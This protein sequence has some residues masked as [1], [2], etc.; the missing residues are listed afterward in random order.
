[1]RVEVTANANGQGWY[2]PIH[3]NGEPGPRSEMYESGLWGAKRAAQVDFPGVPIVRRP[4]PE[5]G[6]P[7][8]EPEAPP[9]V[10]VDVAAEVANANGDDQA[11]RPGTGKG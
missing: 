2:L 8:P 11:G 10:E 4:E 9:E 7:L 5:V 3:N 1:M 6:T